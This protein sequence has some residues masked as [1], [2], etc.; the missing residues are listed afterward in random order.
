M[1]FGHP[2]LLVGLA[3]LPLAGLL[4]LAALYGRR[5][6]L[7]RLLHPE[8]AARLAIDAAPLR[9]RV[10]ALLLLAAA[11]LTLAGLA[12]PRWGERLEPLHARGLD[13]V[14]CIDCSTSMLAEDLAP[15]RLAR[16]RHAVEALLP[17]L[18]G[19]RVGIVAFAGTAFPQCPLT[20]D[21]GA[22]RMFLDLLDPGLFTT[23]GTDLAAALTTAVGLLARGGEGERVVLL[24]SDGEAHG[25]R[26][27][28]AI[29][30]AKAAGVRVFAVGM[31][32]AQGA[33]IPL[34]DRAGRLRGYKKDRR[35]E[36][37]VSRLQA[38]AL[39][40]IARETGGA[41]LAARADGGEVE[42][43]AGRLAGL[44]RA[45]REARVAVRRRERFQLFLL[46]AL[47]LLLLEAAWPEGRRGAW[48]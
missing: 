32:S 20:V 3:A 23:Q 17:R 15:S 47:A 42:A 43:I 9:S 4:F 25:G 10:R 16:A 24:L 21:Y 34:R 12:R 44:A 5:R 11:A 45:E 48:V 33:P 39:E 14:A 8:R 27:E 30:R 31:G 13:L 19:D 1:P 29:G 6:R 18:Q 22:V 28:E 40:R 37:V 36:V 26:L 41:Y 35:G 2:Q 38:A 46:P 7:A